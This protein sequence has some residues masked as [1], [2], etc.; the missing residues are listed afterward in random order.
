MYLLLVAG[1]FAV[2]APTW[3]ICALGMG[4]L[5]DDAWLQWSVRVVGLIGA[6]TACWFLFLRR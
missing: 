5:E 3:V 2:F 6:G 1:L 4:N